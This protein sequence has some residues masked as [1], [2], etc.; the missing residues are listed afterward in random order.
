LIAVFFLLSFSL[1]ASAIEHVRVLWMKNPANE[2]VV[3]WTTREPGENHRVSFDTT[4]RGGDPESYEHHVEPFNSGQF[5]MIKEDEKWV[6][7]GYFH[8]VH[9]KDL[10]PAT[11]YH[12]VIAS[13]GEVSR[14]YH[15]VTALADDRDFA[16]LF[17][18]DSR[19][20][21]AD[22]YLHNDRRKMNE[23]MRSIF[24]QNP[25]IL[26]LVHGGDYCE[27]AEWRYLDAWLTDHT[28]TT[29]GQGRLLP[30]IPARGNH[31]VQIGFEETFSWP[32]LARPYYYTTRLS[33]EVALVTLNTEISMSG[34]QRRWL[35][36]ELPPLREE[37]RWLFVSYHRP[38]YPSV[39]NVQDGASRRDN[40]VPAIERSNVDL[41]CESHDHALKRTLPIRDNK[42]DHENGIIYIGDGGLGVP[43]R[44]PDP[45]RWWFAEPG[46]TKP[47][48]HVHMIEFGKER[49]RV[50]AFGMEGDTLD[51]FSLQP[52]AVAAP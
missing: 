9:L 12:L 24:T 7:P 40:F 14:E 32:D 11:P 2:A 45:S 43:Q 36:N 52:R 44:T 15:F 22:P 4:A 29:T 13:N 51:D 46:F 3:S 20:Q 37:N 39:R 42:P 5:T 48:H 6:K 10:E 18:G 35:E 16:V 27:R 19:I 49:M 50:R 38:A 8:H 21:G 1:P 34:R 26:A 30:I 23:R 47:V 17:G 28:L 31:D 41:V 25:R 33:P